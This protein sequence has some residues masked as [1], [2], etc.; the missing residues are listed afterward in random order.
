M[1]TPALH[2]HD[3]SLTDALAGIIGRLHEQ[4]YRMLQ[5][6]FAAALRGAADEFIRK[7]ADHLRHEEEVLFPALRE[8]AP[9]SERELDDLEEE[10]R[11]LGVYSRELGC[12]IHARDEVG[13]RSVGR[14]F[15]AAL[16][17]HIRR[18]TKV[19]DHAVA[20]LDAPEEA[21]LAEML[22]AREAAMEEPT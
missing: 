17:D 20:W 9:W 2:P 4:P 7:L 16:L 22:R 18:E 6:E 13:V 19:V 21:R 10:H 5:A 12:R 3:G 11:V 1:S 14:S 8:V 15:L